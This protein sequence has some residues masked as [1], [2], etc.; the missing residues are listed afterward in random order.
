M[1]G[2]RPPQTASGLNRQYHD[3]RYYV[4]QIQNHMLTI[5]EEINNLKKKLNENKL[6]ATNFEECKRQVEELSKQLSG[7]IINIKLKMYL[8]LRG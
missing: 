6:D 8:I 4:S 1:T 5:N 3:K 7:I 2:L